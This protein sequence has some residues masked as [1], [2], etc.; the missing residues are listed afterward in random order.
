MR[1]CV[2]N[3]LEEL[4]RALDEWDPRYDPAE[5]M[6]RQPFSSPGYHTTYTGDTVHPT[7]PSA[8]Y[9]LALLDTEDGGRL[10]RAVEV[11]ERVLSLQDTDPESKTY[12]IWSWFLEEPLEQMSP[13]DW[14]WADFCGTCLAQI[15]VD[16][17]ERLRADTAERLDEGTLHAARSIIRRDVGPGYTNIALMGTH[18]TYAVGEFYGDEEILSYARERLQRF[19]EHTREHGAFSE[20]NSPTYTALAARI[21]ARMWRDIRDLEAR[22]HI[23][24]LHDLVWRDIARHYHPPTRQ[25]AGPH[26]RNYSTILGEQTLGFL[27]RA[28]G[29]ELRLLEDSP[30]P[31]I[32]S[33]R[34][35]VRCPTKYHS[36]FEEIKEPREFV[37]V[38]S[39]GTPPVLGRTYMD[40][41]VSLATVNRG[42]FWNQQRAVL[43]YWGTAERPMALQ[44]RVL[45]D[46]YDY[47]SGLVFTQQA[48]PHALAAV[49]FATDGGDT[50]PN[51]DMVR[52]GTIE[53]EDLRL[54][55]QL[56]NA[57]DFPPL[58]EQP[59][60]AQEISLPIGNARLSMHI[61]HIAFGE[62]EPVFETSVEGEDVCLDVVLHKGERRPINF[63]E[64]ES[65]AVI[66][67]LQ[68]TDRDEQLPLP[69]VEVGETEGGLVAHWDSAGGPL[70]LKVL[71]RPG[72]SREVTGAVGGIGRAMITTQGLTKRLGDFQLVDANVRIEE[73]EYFVML[74]PTGAGKTI[75]IECI[76]GIYGPE[77]GRMYIGE[78]DV[79]RW[80]P[81]ERQIG[82]VPQ[83]Y[84]LFPHLTVGG[85]IGF[86][87]RVRKAPAEEIRER[88]LELAELLG[89]ADLLDRP[90][91]TLSGGERQR[92][93]LARALAIR[94]KVL[95]LDEPLSAVD[96]QTRENLCVELRRIHEELKTTTIHVSH[97]FEET[98]SVA[99]RIG[100]IH[101]GVMQQVGTPGEIFRRPANEFVARFVRA[102]N[103]FHGT[104]RP[105]ANGTAL[106]LESGG[107]LLSTASL[108]G[109][110]TAAVRPEDVEVLTEAPEDGAVNCFEGTVEQVLDRGV[111]V[112]LWVST[113]PELKTIVLR[114]RWVSEGL[115]RGRRVWLRVPL[116]AVH[117]CAGEDG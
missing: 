49:L 31:D 52:N 80:R 7:R 104:A 44:V 72:P 35:Q 48:G 5:Q 101:N 85:N 27:Q 96:E 42:N 92:A 88:T 11:L 65:A 18:V 76:A 10:Q 3:N 51:L 78:D 23:E 41:S 106:E 97:N 109:R 63:R 105:A 114:P 19:C 61:A 60:V 55:F 22:P 59:S 117:L 50:H 62:H 24:W 111:T 89:I 47:C 95:L 77:A 33:N 38:Y 74:G 54:R 67:G 15:A 100:V 90:I 71:T 58:P 98:L 69:W 40:E 108:T 66:F 9:A 110:V 28:L 4:T 29:D 116:E 68:L 93:A 56:I 30:P 2:N 45:H 103:I 14:N 94:P 43:G 115:T 84:S 102:E 25:W 53:A 37:Q 20:Y 107:K 83:D 82:Y 87:L 8:E 112:K 81:E 91:R 26:A 75:F 32:E 17:R 73:G 36:L 99:D 64:L 34:L 12:G 79:T 39:K 113:Q 86:G 21:I 46:G 16:H 6:I 1:D 70:E 57:G 13:P